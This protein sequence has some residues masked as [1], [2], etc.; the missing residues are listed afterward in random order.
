MKTVLLLVTVFLS[1]MLAAQVGPDE[2]AVRK[3]LHEEVAAWNK[4]DAEPYAQHFGCR[5]H[6]HQYRGNVFYRT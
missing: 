1:T 4:G 2:M 6:I 3:I 5:W